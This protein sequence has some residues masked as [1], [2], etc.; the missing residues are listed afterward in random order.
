MRPPQLQR[1][2]PQYVSAVADSNRYLLPAPIAAKQTKFYYV[3]ATEIDFPLGTA[4]VGSDF[5]Q[6]QC[7]DFHELTNPTGKINWLTLRTNTRN[8]EALSSVRS[9]YAA[10]KSKFSEDANNPGIAVEKLVMLDE[11]LGNLAAFEA[12][13]NDPIAAAATPVQAFY[14]LHEPEPPGAGSVSPVTPYLTVR[15]SDAG[16]F[17]GYLSFGPPYATCPPTP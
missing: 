11:T 4:N 17:G 15:Y 16:I 10:Y 13:V 7:G 9:H 1:G 2:P 3:I 8:H 12:R 6:A 14:I 5:M